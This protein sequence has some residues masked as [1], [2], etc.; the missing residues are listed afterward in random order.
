VVDGGD[1]T[2]TADFSSFGSALLLSLTAS[3]YEVWTNGLATLAGGSWRPV[4]DLTN[5]ERFVDTAYSDQFYGNAHAN[6]FS[7]TNGLDIFDGRGGIDAADFSRFGSAVLVSLNATEYEAWT[8]DRQTL[9]DGTWRALADLSGI[10]NIVGTA[11]DDLLVGNALTNRLSGL[12]GSDTFYV[13]EGIDTLDGGGG[14]DTADFSQ[15]AAA[16]LVSLT[17]SEYE[18]WTQDQSTLSGGAWRTLAD[19]TNIENIV[20]S[21]FSDQLYGDAADNVFGY[22]GGLDLIDGRGGID[23]ADFSKLSTS[24]LVS[25]NASEYEVWTEFPS[26]GGGIWRPAADLSAIEKLVGTASADEFYGNSEANHFQGGAG[27][28]LLDGRG[29]NDVLAGGL[30]PDSLTGGA[31]ADR[32][33]F[34]ASTEGVD[35]VRDFTS[36]SGNDVLDLRDILIGQSVNAGNLAQYV[37]L[38]PQGQASTMLSVDADGATDGTSFANLAILEGVSG[39]VLSDMLAQGNLAV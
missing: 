9:L 36:G 25:L 38:G 30:G 27:A 14:T 24:V 12:A 3:E 11:Y 8:T 20:G 33:D 15:F 16:V 39:L 18:A 5:V 23:A 19:L 17:A 37:Q 1:G 4:A 29:G 2:D 32:F 10:E 7:Y 6:V 22:V 31:G 26:F 35:I 21:P 28:D 13:S 34:N